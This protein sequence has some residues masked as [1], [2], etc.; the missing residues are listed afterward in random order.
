MNS[1]AK[2]LNTIIFVLLTLSMSSCS[3]VKELEGSL[4]FSSNRKERFDSFILKCSKVNL[5]KENSS[6]PVWSPDGESIA[7]KKMGEKNDKNFGFYLLDVCGK[8]QAFVDTNNV[9]GNLKWVGDNI[10]YAMSEKNEEVLSITP[11][12]LWSYNVIEKKHK[13]ILEIDENEWISYYDI[14]KDGQK[15]VYDVSIPKNM[16]FK[17]VFLF[18]KNKN[19]TVKIEKILKSVWYP[20]G[21]YILCVTHPEKDKHEF[22]TY[23]GHFTKYNIETGEKE[24]LARVPFLNLSGLKISRDGKYVYYAGPNSIYMSPIGDLSKRERITEPV[25]TRSGWS[26]D[27]NPD[28]YQ[29]K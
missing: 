16:K 12:I 25:R 27:R 4:V 7:C 9:M 3:D 8:V 28:W 2:V 23:W 15:I 10:F 17:G 14:S 29:K 1:V 24:Y 11:N 21:K 13:K 19:T 26:Q 5:L 18:D 6:N 20:N 22:G